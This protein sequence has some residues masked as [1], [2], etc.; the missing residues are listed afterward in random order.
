MITNYDEAIAFARDCARSD[1]DKIAS[2]GRSLLAI[3]K[4][5]DLLTTVKIVETLLE[6][7]APDLSQLL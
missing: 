7:K 5:E 1:S 4:D 6:S 2:I 3:K